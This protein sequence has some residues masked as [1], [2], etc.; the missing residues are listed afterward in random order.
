[1]ESAPGLGCDFFDI[2][3][4]AGEGT[5]ESFRCVLIEQH[6]LVLGDAVLVDSRD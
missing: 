6:D 1:V 5:G 4:T 2:S 3:A